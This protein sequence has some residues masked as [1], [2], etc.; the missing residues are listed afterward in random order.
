MKQQLTKY[1]ID[2]LKEVIAIK[3]GEII[4]LWP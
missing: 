4:F 2:N 1:P 3:N